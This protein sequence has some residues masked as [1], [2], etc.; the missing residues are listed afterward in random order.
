M[1]T[2]NEAEI[3]ARRRRRLAAY[4]T[5]AALTCL[6]LAQVAT[7]WVMPRSWADVA[8]VVAFATWALAMFVCW[9]RT[10]K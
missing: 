1:L 6:M 4:W 10:C 2:W 8:A 7:W 9:S 5:D 3:R